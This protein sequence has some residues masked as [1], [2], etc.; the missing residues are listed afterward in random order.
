MIPTPFN[1]KASET[2]VDLNITPFLSLMV[3]LIP[4]LLISAKFSLLAHYD[5]YSRTDD[6]SIQ[7][8]T[9]PYMLQVKEHQVLLSRG[10]Q[11]LFQHDVVDRESFSAALTAYLQTLSEPAPLSISL[12]ASHSYQD[13]V[14]LFDALAPFYKVFSS[15]SVAML[16]TK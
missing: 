14:G 15:M 5:V 3:V 2:E 16:G 12:D 10:E 11:K 9:V 7:A 13:I 1:K 8:S 4:V 6:V